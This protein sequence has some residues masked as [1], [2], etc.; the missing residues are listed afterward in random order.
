MKFKDPEYEL[1]ANKMDELHKTINRMYEDSQNEWKKRG[2][3]EV[4]VKGI[5][6]R[7]KGISLDV[8]D[9][10]KESKRAVEDG[11]ENAMKP[12]EEKVNK[13]ASSKNKVLH[14]IEDQR[15]ISLWKRI[16]IMARL[17]KGV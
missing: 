6:Q 7:T 16:T 5:D 8:N 15:K 10:P 4:T 17:G 11:M 3:M 12:V 13:L 1:L 2:E 14:I 9:L